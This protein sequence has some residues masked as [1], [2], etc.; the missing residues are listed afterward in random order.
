M[1]GRF[2]LY[3]SVQ[4]IVDYAKI[5]NRMQELNPNYN[6]APGQRIPVIINKQD[7]KYFD[8]FQWGLIPFWAKDPKIGYK[9]INSR[10]ETIA[11]KPS[12]KYAFKRRRCLIPANGFYEWR[13]KD[14]QPFYIHLKD[15]ELFTF[16]GIWENW[17]SPEGMNI[18]TCSIITTES[19]EFMQPIHHRMP[20]ILD[21][22][23]EFDWISDKMED[24]KMLLPF[25]KPYE[26]NMLSYEI[27]KEVNSPRN[28]YK[29]LIQ[30]I[31]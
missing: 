6:V 19:N 15:R 27:S 3:S 26:K 5:L 1:C 30:S 13:K 23:K 9:M 25:L 10:A 20:V 17:K 4:A 22:E 2:A 8:I 31:N 12:F 21:R 28:N 18:K 29:E 24:S 7:G 14:K 16:A 11:E